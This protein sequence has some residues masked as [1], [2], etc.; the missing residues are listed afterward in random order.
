MPALGTL[1]DSNDTKVYKIST[2][3]LVRLL[4]RA[5]TLTQG[6]T[7]TD[8]GKYPA[9]INTVEDNAK[10]GLIKFLKKDFEGDSEFKVGYQGK[11]FDVLKKTT[12]P[13]PYDKSL[14]TVLLPQ[15]ELGKFSTDEEVTDT[16]FGGRRKSRRRKTR[17][18]KTRR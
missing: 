2:N 13:R 14:G 18:R 11:G 6:S 16:T 15:I 12:Q 9:A 17:R 7:K 10:N 8:L 1:A 3:T 4:K 5:G